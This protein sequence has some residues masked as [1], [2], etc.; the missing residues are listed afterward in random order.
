[1]HDSRDGV[2]QVLDCILETRRAAEQTLITLQTI[3][4][5]CTMLAGV[6]ATFRPEHW[7]DFAT[8]IAK[9]RATVRGDLTRFDEAI[10]TLNAAAAAPPARVM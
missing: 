1:M 5:V 3:E 7:T 8:S 10:A 2:T 4:Q 9:T 6:G